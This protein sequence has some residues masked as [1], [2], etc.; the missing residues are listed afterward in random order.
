MAMP[1]TC[2][3]NV[4]QISKHVKDSRQ[5]ILNRESGNLYLDYNNDDY[6]NHAIDS[7]PDLKD[8]SYLTQ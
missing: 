8:S 3:K 2:G 5:D 1:P 4:N 6:Y 7:C